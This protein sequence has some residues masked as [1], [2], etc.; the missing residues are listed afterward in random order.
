MKKSLVIILLS[1]LAISCKDAT[2]PVDPVQNGI[3][4]RKDFN[5]VW[6]SYDSLYPLFD[7][8]KIDWQNVFNSNVEKFRQLNSVDERNQ[9]L[10]NILKVFQDEHIY[11][12][13]R[14]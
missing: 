9:L 12:Y 13:P 6:S 8:K 3:D 4:Y 1:F 2:N 11:I 7:Y 10:L 14:G 5:Q